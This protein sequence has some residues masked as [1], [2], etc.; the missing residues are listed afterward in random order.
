MKQVII[1]LYSVIG[2]TLFG[3]VIKHERLS[4][5]AIGAIILLPDLV[6]I[7]CPGISMNLFA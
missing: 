4:R 1:W 7:P 5:H 3:V 2:H 6:N